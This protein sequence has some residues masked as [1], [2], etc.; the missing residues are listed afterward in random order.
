MNLKDIIENCLGYLDGEVGEIG[1]FAQNSNKVKLLIRCANIKIKEIACDYLPLTDECEMVVENGQIELGAFPRRVKEVLSV[2]KGGVRQYFK[3]S[4]SSIFVKTGGRVIVKYHYLPTDIK[5]NDMV[6][7]DSR[8]SDVTLI[9]GV[10]S[11]YCMATGRYEE[12]V[13]WG[14][15]FES[16]MAVACRSN[17]ERFVKVGRWK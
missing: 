12:G 2:T 10:L 13:Y 11:E 3:V 15:K 1:T 7:V 8:V 4:P 9:F 16:G 5:L 14:E 17:R 6:E